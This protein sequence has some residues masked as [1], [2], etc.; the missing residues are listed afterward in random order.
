M[1]F[2]EINCKCRPKNAN[3]LFCRAT[4]LDALRKSAQY[5]FLPEKIDSNQGRCRLNHLIIYFAVTTS[6][7]FVP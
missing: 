7:S 1:F 4:F 6:A 3:L 2:R 5:I